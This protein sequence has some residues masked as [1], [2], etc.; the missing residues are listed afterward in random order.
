MNAQEPWKFEVA[1]VCHSFYNHSAKVVVFF[2]CASSENFEVN[3]R[4][5][6]AGGSID[7]SEG[8]LRLRV[9]EKSCELE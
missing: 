1:T 7:R 9:S 4:S 5:H 8:D 3:S 6:R 2:F